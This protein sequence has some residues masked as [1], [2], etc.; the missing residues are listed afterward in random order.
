MT[1]IKDINMRRHVPELDVTIWTCVW[2]VMLKMRFFR[3]KLTKYRSESHHHL[4]H[5]RANNNEKYTMSMR[6]EDHDA[7]EQAYSWDNSDVITFVLCC[8]IIHYLGADVTCDLA[9]VKR[10]DFTN[11]AYTTLWHPSLFSHGPHACALYTAQWEW[12]LC[13]WTNLHAQYHDQKP[14]PPLAHTTC[15]NVATS[16]LQ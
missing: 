6:S 11:K 15:F 7:I 14:V 3:K 9:F 1:S 8:I 2:Q 12:T 5:R 13:L 4:I 16:S 10:K